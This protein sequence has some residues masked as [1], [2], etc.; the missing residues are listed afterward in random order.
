MSNM[1]VR[2]LSVGFAASSPKG[3]AKWGAVFVGAFLLAVCFYLA[4]V[5]TFTLP[6]LIRQPFGLPPSPEGE[7]FGAVLALVVTFT[8]PP[9]IRQPFGLPPSPEG[10]GF[11]A[12]EL[13]RCR[14]KL[15]WAAGACPR[16]THGCTPFPKLLSR[17]KP[18]DPLR[19]WSTTSVSVSNCQRPLAARVTPNGV[20]LPPV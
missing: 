11:G 3:R 1:H 15:T 4:L 16:P 9:L 6:P 14:G 7:G 2:A 17:I 18:G 20:G 10:E 5:V 19:W 8:L 12:V 13:G